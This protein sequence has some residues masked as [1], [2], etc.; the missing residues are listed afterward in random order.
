MQCRKQF[1]RASRQERRVRTELSVQQAEMLGQPLVN[2]YRV[3][4]GRQPLA[5]VKVNAF[6]GKI[7]VV[8]GQLSEAGIT[9]VKKL[10]EE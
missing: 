5:V 4:M 9:Q 10:L 2:T 7:T 8:S 6:D 1:T 3:L